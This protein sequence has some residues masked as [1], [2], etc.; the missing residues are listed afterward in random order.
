MKKRTESKRGMSK[1]KEVKT[2]KE[3]I[4][5]K[6]KKLDEVRKVRR[7]SFRERV[8]RFVL[9]YRSFRIYANIT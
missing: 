5:K 9:S 1:E 8:E 7:S 4:Q 6:S 2:G 3:P